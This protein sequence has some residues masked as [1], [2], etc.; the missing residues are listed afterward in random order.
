M[1]A[2]LRSTDIA[3]KRVS[4]VA[5]R[6]VVGQKPKSWLLAGKYLKI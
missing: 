6:S 2:I 5:G 3:G 4:L 1:R